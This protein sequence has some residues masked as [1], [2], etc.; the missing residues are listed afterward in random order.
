[1]HYNFCRP[2]LTLTKKAGGKN[3]T[4]AIPA[5]IARAPLSL[6]QLAELLD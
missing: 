6:P 5:G 4:P 1:M 2:H 3:T